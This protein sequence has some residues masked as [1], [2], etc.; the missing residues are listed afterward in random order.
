[1]SNKADGGTSVAI[2]NYN[3]I[4]LGLATGVYGV[5]LVFLIQGTFLPFFLCRWTKDLIDV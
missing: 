2:W 4:A 1:M 5:D 3:K